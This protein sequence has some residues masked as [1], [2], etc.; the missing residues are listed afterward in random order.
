MLVFEL[1]GIDEILAI[2]RR[3]EIP[4]G[5]VVSASTDRVDWNP[6][7]Q[8]RLGGTYL[9]GIV[10]DGRYVSLNGWVFFEMHNPDKCVNVTLDN[11]RYKKIFFEVEDKEAAAKIINEVIHE[12]QVRNK[13]DLGA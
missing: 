4:L 9:P 6:L 10:K 5:H 11:E 13:R 7:K 8:L 2:K 12:Y 1:H 3:I